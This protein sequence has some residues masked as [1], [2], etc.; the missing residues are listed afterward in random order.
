MLNFTSGVGRFQQSIAQ[1]D[2]FQT[3]QRVQ[4]PR[5]HLAVSPTGNLKNGK[6]PPGLKCTPMT[7]VLFRGVDYEEL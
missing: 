4:A 7:V 5:A 2:G 1:L 3:P 6:A